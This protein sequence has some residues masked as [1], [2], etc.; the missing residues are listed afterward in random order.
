MKYVWCNQCNNFIWAN[1]NE[2]Y[3]LECA[4]CGSIDVVASTCVMCG[5]CKPPHS[6]T[7]V[8]FCGPVCSKCNGD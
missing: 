6:M 3:E 5:E 1:I 7:I 8:D 2:D 4:S